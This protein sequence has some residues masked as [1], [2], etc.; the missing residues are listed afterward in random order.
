MRSLFLRLSLLTGLL[1][2]LAAAAQVATP[3]AAVVAT[4]A[5]VDGT[6]FVSRPQQAPVLLARGS[7]LREGDAIN[8][9]RNSS[10]RLKFTDGGETV[11]RP[12]S[13]LHI[14]R[15]QYVQADPAKDNLLLGLL[16]G[17]MRALTGLIGK[18]G[19]HD[20]YQLRVSTATVGIRGT[21]FSV[22]LCQKDCNDVGNNPHRNTATPVAARA[23]QVRGQAQVSR[24]GAAMMPLQ[25]G[26][27]LYSGDVVQTLLNTHVLLAFGDGSRITVNASSQMSIAE[28][29]SQIQPDGSHIGSMIIDMFKGG[30]RFATGLIGKSQPQKVM[31]RTATATVGIRG[32]VFDLVC[33]PSGSTDIAAA[34]ELADMPCDESL[35]AQTREG[36]ITLSG[37]QGTP[38]VLAAGQSGRVNGPDMPARLLPT[39]PGYFQRLDTPAPETVPVDLDALFGQPAPP[40]TSEGVVLAVHEGRV[41]LAQTRQETRQEIFLDAGETAFAGTAAVAPVR[42][43]APAPILDRD[44]LLSSGMF[45]ANMCRK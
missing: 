15:Y 37:A 17:G 36:I 26:Q 12:E 39:M 7:S 6:V 38:L 2:S 16:K 24:A 43:R 31:V 30:L 8:T 25:E 29:A 20:A 9:T 32:T 42:L 35:L 21:D 5:A 44:P 13:I 27:P 4:A 18:R 34:A 10:V 3:A 22:R 11:V 28:Y 33:A 23:L 45:N 40:D 14:Q 1:L 19:N 41:V